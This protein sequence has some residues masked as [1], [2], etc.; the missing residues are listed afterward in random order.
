MVEKDSTVI[1]GKRFNCNICPLSVTL[2]G[3]LRKHIEPVHG[4]RGSNCNISP[5]NL[6]K[7]AIW[8]SILNHFMVKKHSIVKFFNQV[9]YKQ[10]TWKPG[11]IK[12]VHLGK[13]LDCEKHWNVTFVPKDLLKKLT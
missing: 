5:S 8:K 3:S 12:S 9:S 1:F 11:Y 4:G 13:R 6:L 2:K 7:K 10:A